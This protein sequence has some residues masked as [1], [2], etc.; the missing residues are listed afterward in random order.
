MAMLLVEDLLLLLLDPASGRLPVGTHADVAL[1]G[2][3]LADLALSGHVTLSERSGLWRQAR[4]RVNTSSS[5]PADPVLRAALE[6]TAEKERT[7]SVLVTR[8]GKGLLRTVGDRLTASG[9][10]ERHDQKVLGVLPRTRWPE[11]DATHE[12]EV[13]RTLTDVLVRGAEPDARTTSLVAL[14]SAIDRAHKVVDHQGSS[15]REVRRRA[16]Q[17]GAGDWAAQAVRDAVAAAGASAAG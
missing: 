2:A 7:A 14:L 16:K 9:V 12:R 15:R 1:G 8:L 13:R 4:V 3:V 11:R 10:L 17:V 6:Q 5:P